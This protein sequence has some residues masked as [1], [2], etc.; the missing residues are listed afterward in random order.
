MLIG[1]A[2]FVTPVIVTQILVGG[3][4][5]G[6]GIWMFFLSDNPYLLAANG[7]IGVG[8]IVSGSVAV[9]ALSRGGL[10]RW[11]GQPSNPSRL[12]HA[13]LVYGLVLLAVPLIALLVWANATV[14]L[15]SPDFVQGLRDSGGR[16]SDIYVTFLDEFVTPAGILLLGTLLSAFG[17][18]FVTAL[19]A[20]RIE[21]HRMIV[22]LVLIFFSLLF[23]AFFEQ[24]GSSITNFTDRNVDRVFETRVVA[25]DE[26]GS[27]LDLVMTQEQLGFES[28]EVEQQLAELKARVRDQLPADATEERQ[29]IEEELAAMPGDGMIRLNTLDGARD[30]QR[31]LQESDASLGRDVEVRWPVGAAHVGMGVAV[32]NNEIPASTFQSVNPFYILVFGLLFTGLWSF[33]A[34]RRLEPSTPVKFALGLIQLGLGFGALWYGAQQA[35]ERGMVFVGWLMLGYLLHTTGEL[36]LSPVGLSMVTKL[37]PKRLVSTVMGA[38]FLANAAAGFVGAII[39]QF[40]SVQVEEGEEQV[41]PPPSETVHVYGDLFEVI[42]YVALGCGLACLLLSPLLKRWMHVGEVVEENAAPARD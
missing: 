7:V 26:V 32:G 39:S 38:W 40:T 31:A 1:L 37:S 35:D 29:A 36:C 30:D 23:W 9:W 11:A 6:T 18:L 12:K 13:P 25:Q 27:D 34:K 24:A 41:I 33:L 20:P 16:L 10:P 2:V 4:A 15:V 3:G 5:I 21:R 28:R 17:Y 42:A 19:R 22:V 8:L 14:D